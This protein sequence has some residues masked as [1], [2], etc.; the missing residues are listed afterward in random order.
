MPT[1]LRLNGY[2]FFFYSN[3]HLPVHIHIEK[4]DA[5]AKYELMPVML[6]RSK[7][8]TAGELSEIRKLV[9]QNLELFLNKWNEH[10][11]Q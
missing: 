2:R 6:V 11:H 1:I 8:F 4:G 7:K 10:F 3:D 9:E 5:T